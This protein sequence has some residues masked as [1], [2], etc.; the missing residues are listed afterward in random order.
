MIQPIHARWER[1][2][3][4]ESVLLWTFGSLT[5][6]TNLEVRDVV[7]PKIGF[8]LALWLK[9]LLV[10][11]RR[12]WVSH[13]RLVWGPRLVSIRVGNV[14]EM[15]QSTTIPIEMLPFGIQLGIAVHPGVELRVT[16]RDFTGELRPK[17]YEVC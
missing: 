11:V 3:G 13:E 15:V 16:C 17:G 6:V 5:N 2:S 4:R 12:G 9:L 7:Y 8:W 10:L 1:A 14:E